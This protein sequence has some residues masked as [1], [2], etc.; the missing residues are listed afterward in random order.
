MAKNCSRATEV[1]RIRHTRG[2]L[3]R[4]GALLSSEMMII[5][6]VMMILLFGVVETS[7]LLASYNKLK[8]AS[9]VGA[10]VAT[11]TPGDSNQSVVEAVNEVLA[12][13][14]FL[15]YVSVACHDSGQTGGICRVTIQI[16]MEEAAPDLL[17]VLGFRLTGVLEASTAMRKE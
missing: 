10:R 3:R 9:S 2:A 4:K 12:D 7:L 13:T 16:P 8:L 17:G 11:V 1:G 6:P 5:F 15:D 14:S